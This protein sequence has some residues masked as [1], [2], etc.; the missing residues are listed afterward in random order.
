M[1][2]TGPQFKQLHEALLDAFRSRAE[3]DRLALFQLG[4]NLARWAAVTTPLSD[5]AFQLI[6]WAAAHDR[7]SDLILGAHRENR[8]NQQ[9]RRL[10]GELDLPALTAPETQVMICLMGEQPL[11]NLL[12]ILHYHPAAVVLVHS[13]YTAPVA[14]N[15]QQLLDGTITVQRQEVD[16]YA[17]E[18][19]RQALRSVIAQSGWRAAELM[20]NVTGGTKPMSL[21]AYR[22][23]Q[24]LPGC[25]LIYMQTSGGHSECYEYQLTGTAF[26]LQRN[27][28]RT[29]RTVLNID[30]HLRAHGLVGRHG[31]AP[32]PT[33]PHSVS[34]HAVAEAL[35]GYVEEQQTWL[36]VAPDGP[37]ALDLIVRCGN[38]LG[39]IAVRPGGPAHAL[40][41]LR[42]LN[43]LG[44]REYLGIYVKR[45][46]IVDQALPVP[47]QEAAAMRS[48]T[49][50]VL[51]GLATGVL[52][53]DDKTRL[54]KQVMADLGGCS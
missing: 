7:L 22:V 45:F 1:N 18:D 25:A 29:I 39:L 11:P 27:K 37:V 13:D 48:A 54:R 51:A 5:T 6:Q 3:L 19:A 38:Q 47:T 24:D 41:G 15:V 21:A 8:D 40:D 30:L 52:S 16:A 12:P 42:D 46:L 50:L 23:A 2:L 9:V 17:I 31:G 26:T 43:T 44:S 14:H 34:V 35:A 20:F 28:P 4:E 10:A 36:T 49:V 33:T 32:D 53:E